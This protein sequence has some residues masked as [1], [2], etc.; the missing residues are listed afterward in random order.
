VFDVKHGCV[1]LGR[2]V[3]LGSILR[4][5]TS[6]DICYFKFAASI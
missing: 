5:V 2:Q 4:A 6:E 1:L 3:V